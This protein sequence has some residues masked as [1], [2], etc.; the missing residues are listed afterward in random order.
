MSTIDWTS[1][2]SHE[3]EQQSRK[4]IDLV[5]NA[6]DTAAMSNPAFGKF[7]DSQD[8]NTHQQFSQFTLVLALLSK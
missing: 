3:N 8:W 5:A 1:V 2:V 7:W 6:T 4:G